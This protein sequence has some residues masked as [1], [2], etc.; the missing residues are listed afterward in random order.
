LGNSKG[1]APYLIVE[2]GER[3]QIIHIVLAPSLIL[4]AEGRHFP[5]H[6]LQPQS[7]TICTI[8][9][10]LKLKVRKRQKKE[11]VAIQLA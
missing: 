6:F 10:S 7:A 3:G 1:I 9:S 11:D 4:P 5:S 8:E 2:P